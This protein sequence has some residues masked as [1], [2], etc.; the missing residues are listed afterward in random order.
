M[1]EVTSQDTQRLFVYGT[2][3][4]ELGHPMARF[5][6]KHGSFIQ[7]GHMRGRLY[8][9]EDYPGV[10]VSRDPSEKV[11]GTIF[12][13]ESDPGIWKALDSYEGFDQTHPEHSLYLRKIT[14]IYT[15]THML[16][17]WVYVYNGSTSNL[18]RIQSGD[19]I[20]YIGST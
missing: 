8:Q 15:D 17:C 4:T 18:E 10:I 14:N 5:L 12:H 6:E 20:A 19:Y 9:V 1:I 7:R 11:W 16:S 13:L 2:L 3:L